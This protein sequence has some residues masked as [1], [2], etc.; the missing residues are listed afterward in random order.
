VNPVISNAFH[1]FFKSVGI[2][3][4]SISNVFRL[5]IRWLCP[6]HPS[7]HFILSSHCPHHQLAWTVDSC[8]PF[9]AHASCFLSLLLLLS[10]SV[11]VLLVFRLSVP[12][13]SPSLVDDR[14]AR[15]L[16]VQF[17]AVLR[18]RRFAP[19]RIRS[20]YAAHRKR[21]TRVTFPCAHDT[22]FDD[23][24]TSTLR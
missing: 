23:L 21:I 14:S 17:Y 2:P 19:P 4:P 10:F 12:V 20:T 7:I 15:A 18:Q 22:F 24:T 5:Y 8:I 16:S 9:L 13:G 11:F 6:V 1:L 3:L